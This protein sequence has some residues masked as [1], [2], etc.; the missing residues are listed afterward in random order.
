MRRKAMKAGMGWLDAI[1][2]IGAD[3][4]FS[5]DLARH[6]SDVRVSPWALVSVRA[7]AQGVGVDLLHLG[8][9][10]GCE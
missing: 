6:D 2:G 7:L 5:V 4:V 3:E 8:A 10:L 1:G 9:L